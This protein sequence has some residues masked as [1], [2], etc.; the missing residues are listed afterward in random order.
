MKL[1]D[2]ERVFK[3]QA[4]CF[5]QEVSCLFTTRML[6]VNMETRWFLFV[7]FIVVQCYLR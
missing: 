2:D 3:L 7:P 4:R 5:H 6:V 1:L